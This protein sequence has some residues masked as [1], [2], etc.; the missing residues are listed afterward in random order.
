MLNLGLT[1][2]QVTLTRGQGGGFNL[3]AYL[4]SLSDGV[5]Y[6]F[7]QTDRLFQENV[8]PTPANDPGEV[9]GLALSSRQWAGQTLAQYLAAQPE[10]VANGDFATGDLTGWTQA[11]GTSSVL[12]GAARVQANGTSEGR[13][14]QIIPTVAGR[15]Y[16]LSVRVVGGTAAGN[17]RATT[18]T[19][20]A[21]PLLELSSSAGVVTGYFTAT[22]STTYII[23]RI[24]TT[25]NGLYADFDDISVKE[26][27]R[28][29]ATQAT[30]SFRPTYQ[31]GGGKGDATDD[32]LL[33]GFSLSSGDGFLVVPDAQIPATLSATQVLAGAMDGSSN[34]WYLGITT[35]GALRG[36]VG[37]TTLDSTGIDLRNGTHDLAMWTEGSTLYLWANG[38]VVASGAWTG[39]RPTTTWNLFA[40]NNN[41]TPSN[42]SGATVKAIIAGLGTINASRAAQICAAF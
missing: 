12:G 41:G 14:F 34:G 13:I 26:V 4:A 39:S 2:G 22:T 42:F 32:R 27:S 25:T 19:S 16:R 33:T 18:S 1:L 40:L 24:N 37:Q 23:L 6:D 3:A 36:K 31:T 17:V 8:G 29:A 35:G 7:L 20:I 9:I 21:S 38:A 10:L 11:L 28:Y 30:N 15:T 5:F